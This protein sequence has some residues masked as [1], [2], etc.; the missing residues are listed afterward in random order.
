MAMNN[1]AFSY[2][3]DGRRDEALKLREEVLALYRKVLSPE[4]PDTLR[5]MRNLAI[6]YESANRRD[7][8]LNLREQVLALRRK[9]L[10]P[11]HPDTISSM[12]DLANSYAEAGR[13]QEAIAL[14]E[15]HC[16]LDPKDTDA[17]LTLAT[18]Q[19]WFAQ[20]ADYEAT[21]RRLVLQAQGTDQAATAE[22][23]AKAVCLRSSTDTALLAKALDLAQRAVELG[24]TNSSL[25]RYQLTLGLAEYRN[26]QNAAAER[27]I[28]AAE[29]TLGQHEDVQG[30][31]HLFYAMT[32]FR[33]DR[34][35]EAR[36]IFSQA[37]A[38]M[39][40]LPADESKPIVDGKTFDHDL[41]IW[42]LSYK[43]ARSLLNEPA[44]ANP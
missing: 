26:G 32:L 7:E 29:Q 35:E 21:R 27:S 14:L 39:P 10:G 37:Q 17:P 22:R 18:W 38:Q 41:L 25:P 40:P 4:H 12:K 3:D 8:A 24:Q 28:A 33:Q 31:A 30:I 2:D 5:A 15:K 13:Q 34:V 44:A 9:V 36:K 16:E 6:S 43:E 11:K 42:W 19:A 23:A 1:L 20:D